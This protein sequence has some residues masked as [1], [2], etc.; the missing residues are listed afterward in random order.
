MSIKQVESEFG[1]NRQIFKKAFALKTSTLTINKKQ[2][3]TEKQTHEQTNKRT[4]KQVRILNSV[5]TRKC[6]NKAWKFG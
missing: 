1:L 2:K 4:E 5:L 6:S 3:K